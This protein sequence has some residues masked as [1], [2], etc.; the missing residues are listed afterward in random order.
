M[1][2]EPRGLG[3]GLDVGDEGKYQRDLNIVLINWVVMK[4]T[5]AWDKLEW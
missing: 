4:S 2:I 5:E 1:E 3:N